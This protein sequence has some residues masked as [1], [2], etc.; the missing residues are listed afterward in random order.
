MNKVNRL[1][2]KKI[3]SDKFFTLTIGTLGSYIF[4]IIFLPILTRIYTP[5]EFSL[6]AIYITVVQIVSM[7]STLKFDL[8]IPIISDYNDRIALLRI[9]IINM[10]ISTVLVGSSLLLYSIFF[11]TFQLL[12]SYLIPSGIILHTLFTH[13]LYNWL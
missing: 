12:L 6:Y 3:F 5:N 1:P 2:E 4:P 10:F 13:V 8:A 9:S 11:G 7:F